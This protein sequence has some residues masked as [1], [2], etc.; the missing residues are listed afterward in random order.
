M[1]K[2]DLVNYYSDRAALHKAISE[3]ESYRPGVRNK[4]AQKYSAYRREMFRWMYMKAE[5][6]S[7]LE[8]SS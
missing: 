8:K 4:S 6:F 1:T 7:S 2:D 5:Q 3:D